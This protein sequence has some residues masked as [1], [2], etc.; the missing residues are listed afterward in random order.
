MPEEQ[1]LCLP[2]LPDLSFWDSFVWVTCQHLPISH[3]SELRCTGQEKDGASSTAG[4]APHSF[5]LDT[6]GKRRKR[7][8]EQLCSLQEFL[9]WFLEVFFASLHTS[10]Y[11]LGKLRA[12][13]CALHDLAAFIL[14]FLCGPGSS[15]EQRIGFFF[16]PFFFLYVHSEL[17][18]FL[19]PAVSVS[20]GFQ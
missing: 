5:L 18:W 10:F 17:C 7:G 20:R 6:A 2:A 11:F 3:P 16:A 8:R 14:L 9:H 15:W 4:L 12:V 19:I 13:L 1:G